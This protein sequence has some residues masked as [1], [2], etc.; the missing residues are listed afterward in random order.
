MKKTFICILPVLLSILSSC[1]KTKD[2]EPTGP[3]VGSFKGQFRRLHRA[4]G[5]TAIDTLKANITVILTADYTFKVVGDTTTVHA[6]SLGPYGLSGN[7]MVF[8]DSTFPKVGK[9]AK[10]HLSGYYQYFYDGS[11]LLQMVA[12]SADTLSYQ[13]DLKKEL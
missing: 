8:Q 13:Y 5:A 4:P 9:P 11:S 10:I 12:N 3:I 1:V 2:V 6:G 7:T